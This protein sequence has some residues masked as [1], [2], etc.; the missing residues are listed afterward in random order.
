MLT[1]HTEH[2]R[3]EQNPELQT[4]DIQE[5]ENIKKYI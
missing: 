2:N 3:T 5:N 1:T 4:K